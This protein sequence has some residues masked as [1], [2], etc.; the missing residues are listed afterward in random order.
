[1]KLPRYENKPFKPPRRI[2]SATSNYIVPRKVGV[3]RSYVGSST[4]SVVKRPTPPTAN[5]NADREERYFTIMY[6]KFTNK[7]NKTWNGDGYAILREQGSL[8]LLIYNE[9]GKW[10]GSTTKIVEETMFDAVLSTNGLEFQLDYEIDNM[11]E[12][13]DVKRKLL[14]LREDSDDED[15]CESISTVNSNHT[16]L[17]NNVP[18]PTNASESKINDVSNIF[19]SGVRS[20]FKPV[21]KSNPANLQPMSSMAKMLNR[22]I[23]TR[24]EVTKK[25]IY[26]PL[27]DASTIEN[28]LIMNKTEHNEI[29]VIVDPLISKLLRPHQRSGVK[30]I[31]DCLLGMETKPEALNS[32]NKSVVLEADADISGC[33]LADDMGLGKTLTTIAVIWTLLRQTPMASLVPCSQSGT[34]LQGLFNK[35]LVVCPVTLIGNW[36]RE[37]QKWLGQNRIGVLT[38]NPKNNGEMDKISV[39]NFLKVNRTYQVLIIGY[40][41]LLTVKDELLNQKEKL[42]LLVCDEGH[43][44]KNGSSKILNVLKELQIKRKLLLTGTPI[45]NDLNEFYTIIDFVNPGVLGTYNSFKRKFI[46]PISKAR[47]VNNKY[48]TTIIEIGE[49][50][51]KELIELTKKFILRRQSTILSRFLPPKTDIILFCKPTVQQIEAFADIIENVKV[52]LNN[53]TFN[54]TLGLINLMK[55]VC[56]SPSLITND[57]FFRSSV[58]ISKTMC[59]SSSFNSGKLIVLMEILKELQMCCPEEKI[60]IVSNYTQTLDIIENLMNQEKYSSCRLDGSTPPKQRDLI[61]NSFNKNPK[62]FSFLLSAKAGGV[63]LNL[64]GASRLILF[65]NDWNPAIDFQAMSRIHREGQ[66]R[67]CFIYRL[68][69]TGCIDEK[70]LQRQLMKHNLSKKFLENSSNESQSKANDDLFDKQDLKDLFTIRQHTKSNTHDLICNCNGEGGE[71]ESDNQ[72]DQ[73]ISN[74]DL[75]SWSS[76]LETHKKLEKLHKKFAEKEKNFIKQ[77]LIGYRHIDPTYIEDLLDD[78]LSSVIKRAKNIVTFAFIQ[79]GQ[80]EI[81]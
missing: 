80:A 78:V 48:N 4:G 29:E 59:Y 8:K 41:K 70:I 24:N 60:V 81:D 71:C 76:A 34:P 74:N 21:L 45:Q 54:S 36:K 17:N 37:F 50:K 53:I 3:K 2:G 69:T 13:K 57:P 6:R 12:L 63:G 68:V 55:K 28:P 19:G 32:D 77:C 73:C 67:P 40:E 47:D 43:R 49:E 56:N 18:K 26:T 5:A 66:K 31:Y 46:T 30:F 9:Q 51:S 35:V 10:L 64:I 38:L 58:P 62:I 65:D 25:I 20:R 75:T 7:K 33:I 16:S 52:D 11:D 1:M 22:K 61:V 27:F 72:E 79:P 42:G 39:R 14:K 15:I 23:E 44:L